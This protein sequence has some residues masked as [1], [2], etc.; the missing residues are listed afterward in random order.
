MVITVPG[1]ILVAGEYAVL[2]NGGL[3]FGLAVDRRV[4]IITGPSSEL[5]ITTKFDSQEIVYTG[6]KKQFPLFDTVIKSAQR[7]LLILGM[8]HPKFPVEIHLDSSALF[9]ENG[10]KLGLGSSA[11]VAVGLAYALLKGQVS[12]ERLLQ[13]VFNTALFAHIDF[14]GGKGSGYDVAVSTFGGCGLFN[15]GQT[16]VWVASQPY[17]FYE[18]FLLVR[19]DAPVKSVG[20]V[21]K[22]FKWKE[23]N[24]ENATEFLIR[25]N[26]IVRH[27]Y[28][29]ATYQDFIEWLHVARSTGKSLG[30]KIGVSSCG[31]SLCDQLGK[32]EKM[33]VYGKPS[34]AGSEIGIAF[35]DN[36]SYLEDVKHLG[37]I[38]NISKEGVICQK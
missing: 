14:Q 2:E 25:S 9:A 8:V 4:K 26:K 18:K 32:L 5:K 19:G 16:P 12:E 22:Y 31:V 28:K 23:Q 3:G 21:D 15:G 30:V 27:I 37:E 1:N 38:V 7:T 24:N 10:D 17:P 34:G 35:S 36:N 6:K 13:T 33:H 29:C 11:A 20:S